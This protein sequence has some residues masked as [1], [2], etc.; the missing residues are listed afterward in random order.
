MF[1][2]IVEHFLIIKKLKNIWNQIVELKTKRVSLPPSLLIIF[3][4]KNH[5]KEVV[6][7]KFFLQNN[8]K[9]T[10][11]K[12]LAKVLISERRKK[13]NNQYTKHRILVLGSEKIYKKTYC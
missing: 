8:I 5:N 7:F 13:K 6:K 2:L 9:R 10:K 3:F 4:F 12:K 11:K 1:T